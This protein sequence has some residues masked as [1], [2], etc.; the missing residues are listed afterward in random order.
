MLYS[1][2]SLDKLWQRVAFSIKFRHEVHLLHVLSKSFDFCVLE[3]YDSQSILSPP[4]QLFIV[5][6]KEDADPEKSQYNEYCYAG[7]LVEYVRWLNTDKASQFLRFKFP[8][9][10]TSHLPFLQLTSVNITG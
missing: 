3:L 1:S 5:L 7:G 2:K 9:P 10:H 6:K 4:F 8:H